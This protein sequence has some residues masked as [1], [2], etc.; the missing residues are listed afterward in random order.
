MNPWPEA[1]SDLAAAALVGRPSAGLVLGVVAPRCPQGELR[2]FGDLPGLGPDSLFELASI[3]KTFTATLFELWLTRRPALLQARCGDFLPPGAPPVADQLRQVPLRSILSYSS[4]L[5]SDNVYPPGPFPDYLRFPGR[6]Y[7]ID[8]L[9]RHAADP[10]FTPSAP[11]LAYTY[12]SFGFALLAESLALAVGEP[13][14]FPGLMARSL[15]EPLGMRATAMLDATT[16]ARMPPC[17]DRHGAQAVPGAGGFPAHYGSAGLVTTPAD[18]MIW[19]RF[20]MG[21][22]A[23][24]PF[25]TL[26]PNLQLPATGIRTPAG[27]EAGRGFFLKEIAEAEGT[28]RIVLKSGG[29]E[30]F[31]AL[32]AF[33]SSPRPGLLPSPGGLFLLANVH[34]DIRTL[35]IEALRLLLSEEAPKSR[36]RLRQEGEPR[37]FY[38]FPALADAAGHAAGGIVKF[39]SLERLFP[40]DPNNFDVCCLVSSRLPENAVELVRKAHEEGARLLYNQAGVATPAT[41]GSRWRELNQPLA[42]LYAAADYVFYQSRFAL[43]LAELHFGRRQGPAE[44]LYNAV[45]TQTFK[46]AATK[47]DPRRPMVLL[48]GTQYRWYRLELGL[49]TFA[50]L[51]RGLPQAHLLISGQLVWIPDQAVARQQAEELVDALGLR[52]HVSFLG[53]Y[54]Q[55][56]APLVFH[57]ANVLLHPMVHDCCPSVVL[58]AMAS[59]LPVVY[60][61]SGGVPE[62]V[63]PE[64][65]VGVALEEDFENL[66]LPAPEALAQALAEALEARELLGGAGR[67]RAVER[68]DRAPWLRR[69]S[70]LIR[71]LGSVVR[72]PCS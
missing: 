64:A 62:L 54:T 72:S 11:G 53:S 51:R 2:Y 8:D 57:R 60:V 67:V 16:A 35:G 29:L 15:L 21:Y 38:G 44:I 7:E 5:P 13:G 58:E 31:T 42:T 48:G 25:S 66:R 30:A 47:P 6:P 3:S 46:P 50:A 34:L 55:R 26:L 12:S 9:F 63:G 40:N 59:G 52:E 23:G 69:Y 4:G 28:R 43:R 70:E 49:R 61:Q 39:Q 1:L 36:V 24:H 41:H 65:G 27:L 10:G 18:F 33:V 14:G 37:V 17:F 56:E 20:Q 32:V 68:F 22:L 19:L 45:D 71:Q